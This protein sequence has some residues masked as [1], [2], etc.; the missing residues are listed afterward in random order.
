MQINRLRKE[1]VEFNMT[2]EEKLLLRDLCA[3]LTYGTI[4]SVSDGA[5]KYNAYIEAVFH[6]YLQVSPVSD[7]VFTAYTYYKIGEIK[8]YLRPISSM[9]EEEKKEFERIAPGI[10]VENGVCIPNVNQIDYLNA[11]HFDYRDL[12]PKGL[13]IEVT[14]ENNPYKV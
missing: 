3:R 2:Q 7:S 1:E 6:K 14:K 8:P 5:I 10:E 13:A 4:V 12:I 11:N 9:T